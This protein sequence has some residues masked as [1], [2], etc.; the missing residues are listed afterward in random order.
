MLKCVEC[1]KHREDDLAAEAGAAIAV[2]SDALWHT[3]ES[4]CRCAAQLHADDDNISVVPA[5]NLPRFP[6]HAWAWLQHLFAARSTW[7]L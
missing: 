3:A 7:Q 1:E 4:C 6:P 5:Q 2:L